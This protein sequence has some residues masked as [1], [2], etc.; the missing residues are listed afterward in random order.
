MALKTKCE[1]CGNEFLI[2]NKEIEFYK[3]KDFPLPKK[4]PDCRLERR[5]NLRDKKQLLGY[6]CDNCNKDIVVAFEPEEGQQVFCK[7][8]YQKYMQE[9][10][11]IVG[12]SE[13]AK[14]K[15]MDKSEGKTQ[16]APSST[17]KDDNTGSS[18]EE[19]KDPVGW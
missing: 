9:N 15:G 2:I 5:M 12:Y 18:Q 6:K 17:P 19:V 10:D 8:C 13:G 16:A 4:C 14:A 11:C 7:P 3:E 1:K